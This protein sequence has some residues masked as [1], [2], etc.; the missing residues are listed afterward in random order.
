MAQLDWVDPA[1]A[2]VNQDPGFR[3]LGSADLVV[4]LKSGKA[5]RIVAFE[6]FEVASVDTA[7]EAAL[8]DCELIIGTP[9]NGRT[10]SPAVHRDDAIGNGRTIWAVDPARPSGNHGKNPRRSNT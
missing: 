3:K 8:R 1:S 6:A 10:I 4:G 5:V 2:A 7:D 9:G